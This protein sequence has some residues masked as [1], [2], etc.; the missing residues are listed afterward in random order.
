MVGPVKKKYSKLMDNL[1]I[2]NVDF[3][4]FI[5]Y[6]K[7]PVE[8]NKADIFLGGHFSDRDK[9]KRVIS[10]KTFQSLACKKTTIV[11]DGKASRELFEEGSLVHFVNMNNP[12]DL[13]DKILEIKSR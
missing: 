3:V 1:N 7:L 10:G 6:E 12:Q 11:G 8:I 9:A 5:P 4:E 13:A 2:K